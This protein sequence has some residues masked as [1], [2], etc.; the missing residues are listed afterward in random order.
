MCCI[1]EYIRIDPRSY[2]DIQDIPQLWKT[3][4]QYQKSTEHK[5]LAN[6]KITRRGKDGTGFII[7]QYPYHYN[8]FSSYCQPAGFQSPPLH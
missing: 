6:W 7:C 4:L 3:E 5:V 8:V 1:L 2:L